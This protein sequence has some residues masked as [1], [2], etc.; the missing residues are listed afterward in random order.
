MPSAEELKLLKTIIGN[1]AHDLRTP[2]ATL[3]LGASAYE[4]LLPTISQ[5][6][7]GELPSERLSAQTIQQLEG[8]SKINDNMQKAVRLACHSLELMLINVNANAINP[9]DFILCSIQENI[10]DMLCNYPLHEDEKELIEWDQHTDFAYSGNNT[11]TKH[12][13]FNLLKNA[14]Y[15]VKSSNNET[16]K[17]IITVQPGIEHNILKF[18]D[19]GCGI[20]KENID[21]IFDPY[22]STRT[23]GNGLGLPFCRRVMR[24]YNGRIECFSREQQYTEFQLRF[25]A[26][27]INHD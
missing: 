25:P 9:K 5:V 21:K 19:T 2:L 1:I 3:N 12:M 26:V 4:K 14:L 23:A 16:P 15:A 11:L 8:L 20:T 18:K 10:A 27:Q 6:T 22:Y 7:A 13:L 17:V 24:A